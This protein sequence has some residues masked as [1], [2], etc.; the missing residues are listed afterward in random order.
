MKYRSKDDIIT[1][2]SKTNALENSFLKRSVEAGLGF[3]DLAIEDP[4]TLFNLIWH[5]RWSS[6][7][8]TPG[9]WYGGRLYTVKEVAQRMIQ[10]SYTF[11]GLSDHAYRGRYE[12]DWFKSCAKINQG[13]SWKA[14]HSLV[15]Q[16]PTNAERL[17]CP[18]GNFR[19]ID[20]IHR[21]LV[22]AVK[23]LK[24]EIV[25]EPVNAILVISNTPKLW[26]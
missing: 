24:N 1:Q 26:G 13:F 20:G 16:L 15:V 18:H 6:Q 4:E 14:F 2:L 10:K 12:A 8:L 23:L 7:I 17:D 5:Y 9:R 3:Y 22:A 19:L 25:F 21:S 11:E